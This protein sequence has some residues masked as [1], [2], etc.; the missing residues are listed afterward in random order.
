VASAA[1]PSTRLGGSDGVRGRRFDAEELGYYEAAER[2]DGRHV[3]GRTCR[4]QV[5]RIAED[6]PKCAALIGSEGEKD[7]EFAGEL[8]D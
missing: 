7:A 5:E 8:G 6:E 1:E 3:D 2:G 4:D